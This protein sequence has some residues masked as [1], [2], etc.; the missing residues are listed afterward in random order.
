MIA[1]AAFICPSS[2]AGA[3]YQCSAVRRTRLAGAASEPLTNLNQSQSDGVGQDRQRLTTQAATGFLDDNETFGGSAG[4]GKAVT[5]GSRYSTAS[6]PPN[7]AAAA[8]AA[9]TGTLAR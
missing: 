5:R 3:A 1:G 9:A 8:A 7:G 2:P 6:A 4:A